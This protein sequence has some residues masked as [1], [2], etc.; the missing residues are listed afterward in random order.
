MKARNILATISVVM[1]L[2]VL[3]QGTGSAVAIREEQIPR[4]YPTPP[5]MMEEFVEYP[6]PIEPI[7]TPPKIV[8]DLPIE[9]YYSGLKFETG[10]ILFS[11]TQATLVALNNKQ[12][13][14]LDFGISYE[15]MV[16]PTNG[17][18][19]Q[20]PE[21]YPPVRCRIDVNYEDW[22]VQVIN[23][24]YNTKCI[25]P[26]PPYPRPDYRIV[27]KV[28]N[29]VMKVLKSKYDTVWKQ[30]IIWK[31]LG[32]DESA[33]RKAWL[34]FG[35][36]KYEYNFLNMAHEMI[37]AKKYSI[38]YELEQAL[39]L[40]LVD[41]DY[42]ANGYS[43]V[44]IQLIGYKTVAIN[45]PLGMKFENKDGSNQNLGIAEH[46]MVWAPAGWTK[47]FEVKTYCINAHLGV[48]TTRDELTPSGFVNANVKGEMLIQYIA[49]KASTGSAQ[50]AVW[51]ETDGSGN[52]YSTHE[53]EAMG[54][55]S[56]D[57]AWIAEGSDIPVDV[58]DIEPY[59]PDNTDMQNYNGDI[60]SLI[61]VIL[62]QIFSS[63]V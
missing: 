37:Y 40:G 33:L 54:V 57:L 24:E 16:Y 28:D 38:G 17:P 46:V 2:V 39:K 7:F 60:N 43:S 49:G 6:Y 14:F 42:R 1:L 52:Q 19:V 3:F 58:V 59:Q 26:Y 45:I 34:D 36:T 25:P 31:Y 20:Y 10:D 5:I 35:K 18:Y 30:F 41:M 23:D 53:L 11:S 56:E 8:V 15:P 62:N 27:G 48:P 63:W 44:N 29:F 9:I 4:P 21:Y 55:A 22:D 51:S 13:L 47:R 12:A 61:S 32:V 50:S